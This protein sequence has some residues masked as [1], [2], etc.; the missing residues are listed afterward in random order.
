MFGRNKWDDILFTHS[1]KTK[2]NTDYFD[3]HI[4]DWF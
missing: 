1:I 4:I 2:I 3:G